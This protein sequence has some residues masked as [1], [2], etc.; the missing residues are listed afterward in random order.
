LAAEVPSESL[1][2]VLRQ[3]PPAGLRVIA[4]M[5]HGGRNDTYLVADPAGRRY[6]LRR[7]RRNPDERRIRFQLA[8]Q[9]ELLRRRYPTSEIVDSAAGPLVRAGS[10][11]WVLFTYVE[12]SAYDYDSMAQVAEAGRRLA[13]FHLLTADID[14]EDVPLEVNPDAR[15][16]LTHGEERLAA[17]DTLCAGLGV[18]EQL[19]F[20]RAW[21][22]ELVAAVPLA[23]FDALPGGWV[24]ADFHGRN[25]VFAGDALAGLFDFDPLYRGRWLEDVAM[26]LF[27]FAREARQSFNIRQ[28]AARLFLAEYERARPLTT[29][30]RRVLPHFGPLGWVERA[31]YYELVR[32]DGEDWLALFRLHVATM[33]AVGVQLRQLAI[34]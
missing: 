19:A 20:L 14:L 24:H 31:A 8:F 22:R 34:G 33:R 11:I 5:E 29:D 4:P 18:D 9:R 30:E 6:V 3:Y 27:R 2:A 15:G 17:L 1:S 25:M 28:D 10:G 12:G 23:T 16:W 21:L 13:Q 32:R 26:S 7:Y